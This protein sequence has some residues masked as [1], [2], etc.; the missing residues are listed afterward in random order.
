MKNIPPDILECLKPETTLEMQILAD[1]HI[2]EGLYWGTPRY[3]HPEGK[4]LY[5]IPEIFANIDAIFP[6][7][8]Q[9]RRAQLRLIA[10]IHDS[11]KFQEIKTFPRDW[12]KHHGILAANYAQK[13]IS[14]AAV[15][16]VTALH[17]EAYYCWR[18][19]ILEDDLEASEQRLMKLYTALGQNLQLFYEFFKCDTATGDKTQAP[20]KWF[21]QRAEVFERVVLKKNWEI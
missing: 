10:L 14:D 13:Y 8:P 7:P 20:M 19:A 11:F 3:G 12:S 18:L 15:L 1:S 5:H 6:A 17:D 2:Q 21:E 16:S 4:V 9:N